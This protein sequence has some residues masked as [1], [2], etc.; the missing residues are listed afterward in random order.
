MSGTTGGRRRLS[1]DLIVDRAL[2][3]IE[4]RGVA[5]ATMRGLGDTLGVQAMSL[6]RYVSTRDDLL[7]KVVDRIV[8][9]LDD[10]SDLGDPAGRRDWRRYLTDLA[11]DV[12][13]Y[14]REHPEAF[15]LLSTRPVPSTWLRPPVRSLPWVEQLFRTLRADGFTA[16]AAVDAYRRFNQFLLGALLGDS[17]TATLRRTSSAVALPGSSAGVA[18]VEEPAVD[19]VRHPTVASMAGQLS[20]PDPDRTFETALHDVLDTIA[21]RRPPAP[22]RSAPHRSDPRGVGTARD[23]RTP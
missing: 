14:S 3:L 18:P 15:T 1:L 13:A 19:P 17:T 6:Y 9:E 4:D 16:A 7:D 21:A 10:D 20:D 5:A 22:H 12:R 23:P 11:H 8:S 2:D